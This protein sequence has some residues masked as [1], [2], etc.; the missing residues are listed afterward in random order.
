MVTLW[1]RQVDHRHALWCIDRVVVDTLQ[2][3]SMLVGRV[4]SW[5]GGGR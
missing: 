4:V 1:D 3:V 5:L 2:V